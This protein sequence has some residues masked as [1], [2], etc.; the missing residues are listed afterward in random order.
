MG[1]T[2]QNGKH[3][4]EIARSGRGIHILL[5]DKVAGIIL[6]NWH[7]ILLPGDLAAG[8]ALDAAG[9]IEVGHGVKDARV[10]LHI[11]DEK[12]RRV[13]LQIDSGHGALAALIVRVAGVV[14]AAVEADGLDGPLLGDDVLQRSTAAAQPTVSVGLRERLSHIH[15]FAHFAVECIGC[16]G[17]FG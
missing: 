3:A 4:L 5:F 9:Q 13:Y 17:G 11:L 16:G 2:Y 7:A 14:G 10:R 12:W 15:E 6:V 8:H 1:S